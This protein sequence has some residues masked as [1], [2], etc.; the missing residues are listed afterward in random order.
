MA[1]KYQTLFHQ[2]LKEQ[3][4]ELSKFKELHDKYAQDPDQYQDEYNKEGEKFLEIIRKYEDMLT[5]HSENS[6]YG[7]FSTNLS[8]KFRGAVKLIYPKLDFIGLKRG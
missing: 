5:S 1:A 6:G 4:E 7:K 2:M 3:A 8:E